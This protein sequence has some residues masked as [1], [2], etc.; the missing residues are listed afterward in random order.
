[1]VAAL[2]LLLSWHYKTRTSQRE[3]EKESHL[4]VFTVAS[5]PRRVGAAR[6]DL[7]AYNW[8]N[9]AQE[10]QGSGRGPWTHTG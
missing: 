4:P 9:Q 7:H 6:Q 5:L 2:N 10:S 8:F 1:M 3:G